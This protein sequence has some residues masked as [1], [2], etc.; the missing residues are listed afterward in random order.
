[1]CSCKMNLQKYKK[2]AV[3]PPNNVNRC[4]NRN[5]NLMTHV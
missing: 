2:A 5:F 4:S 3:S 1:M